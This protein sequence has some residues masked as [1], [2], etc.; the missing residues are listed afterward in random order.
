MARKRANGEG[1]V[2]KR[3]D[4]RWEGRI[5]VGHKE[6]GDPITKSVFAKTQK[7]LLP[8]NQQQFLFLVAHS[9]YT[10]FHHIKYR[11]TVTIAAAI[12]AL[13]KT[14]AVMDSLFLVL[15]QRYGQLELSDWPQGD[16]FHLLVGAPIRGQ[17]RSCGDTHLRIGRRRQRRRD[18]SGRG[19]GRVAQNRLLVEVGCD[20]RAIFRR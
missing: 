9:G 14:A 5:V 4:G 20:L 13:S 16:G 2:K 8:E 1:T 19:T 6:N 18:P 11:M 10:L 7:E 12:A 17:D 3:S 15:S